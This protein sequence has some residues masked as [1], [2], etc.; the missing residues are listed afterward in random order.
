MKASVAV[1]M[2]AAPGGSIA[3]VQARELPVAL[4]CGASGGPATGI[5]TVAVTGRIAQPGGGARNLDEKY[6]DGR[7]EWP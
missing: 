3:T 4:Q 1:T 6:S 7:S 5:R 2:M